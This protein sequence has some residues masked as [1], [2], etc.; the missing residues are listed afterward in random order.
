MNLKK[1]DDSDLRKLAEENDEPVM[2]FILDNLKRLSSPDEVG[3]IKYTIFASSSNSEAVLQAS[4]RAAKLANAPIEFVATLNQVD[5]DG[6]YTGWNQKALVSKIREEAKNINF[7][8]PIIV[9]I[10]HGGPWLKDIQIIENWPLKKCMDWIKNSFEEA[11]E[12]GYD[13]IHVDPTV[14]LT[15]P[16][17]ETI[18]IDVVADRTLELIKHTENF[19]RK[20][21]YPK[22]S[23]EVGTEEVHG[24]LA[25][26]N[27]FRR[28]LKL[29]KDGLKKEGL[30]DVWPCFIVGKVGTDLHTTLFDKNV[31][32][33][34]VREASKFGSFIK[35]HYTD[36]VENPE[37]YPLVGMGGANLGPEFTKMEYLELKKLDKIEREMWE[38]D[39]ISYPS[40]FIETITNA[41]IKSNRWK[42]WLV[43]DEKG[44]NFEDL[45]EERKEW[46]IETGCRYVWTLPEVLVSRHMLY[47]NLS[48]KGINAKTAVLLNIEH[49]MD[50][51]FNAFNLININDRLL[52]FLAHGDK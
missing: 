21:N 27:V 15:L 4:L 22:I 44:K 8:G 10:D 39:E 12:A 48:K 13:L 25:D 40:K 17:G 24:G 46:L 42:K 35:G 31:A 52:N 49:S 32:S 3:R 20:N 18:S 38:K 11:I 2:D 45:G 29:L 51:Y 6:G 16:E 43:S 1:A 9:A 41:V 5:I 30:K 33:N 23:Y 50:R 47:E 26:K 14:D 7:G 36:F 19:R 34:L 37:N 28:F